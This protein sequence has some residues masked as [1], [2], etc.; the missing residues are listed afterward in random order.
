MKLLK[1]YIDLDANFCRARQA[2]CGKGGWIYVAAVLRQLFCHFALSV[3]LTDWRE[4]AA[5]IINSDSVPHP[6][7]RRASL[8][9][10]MLY[11][12]AAGLI[13]FLLRSDKVDAPGCVNDAA[14]V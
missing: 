11:S 3:R 13:P 5:F 9:G 8:C 6:K 7:S 10:I 12:G 14:G 1:M 4:F 2:H